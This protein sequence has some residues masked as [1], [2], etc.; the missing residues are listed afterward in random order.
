[1]PQRVDKQHQADTVAQKADQSGDER[2]RNAGQLSATD[3]SED[4]VHGSRNQPFQ[5]YDLQRVR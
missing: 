2:N 1:M 3:Q 5:L 4:E